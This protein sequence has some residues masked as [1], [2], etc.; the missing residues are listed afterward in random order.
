[1][2]DVFILLKS[3][4]KWDMIPYSAFSNLQHAPWKKVPL[5]KLLGKC[6]FMLSIGELITKRTRFYGNESEESGN[7]CLT[8]SYNSRC[9]LGPVP[10]EPCADVRTRALWRCENTVL[11]PDVAGCT[12]GQCSST[13]ICCSVALPL[14]GAN[15]RTVFSDKNWAQTSSSLNLDTRHLEDCWKF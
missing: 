11:G 10:L 6:I 15:L 1:M 12:E 13:G 3:P 14:Y 4:C 2:F 9:D 7:V 8:C 5:S